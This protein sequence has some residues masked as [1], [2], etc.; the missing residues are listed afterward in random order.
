[1]ELPAAAVCNLA[2][3]L[4]E[5]S[6]DPEENEAAFGPEGVAKRGGFEHLVVFRVEMS[7]AAA[8]CSL[9]NELIKR[10]GGA[11]KAFSIMHSLVLYKKSRL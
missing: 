11:K 8:C 1:M 3:E 4:Q 9:A 5:R 7:A 10:F 6:G 2:N